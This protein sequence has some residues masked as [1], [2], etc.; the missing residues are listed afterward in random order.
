MEI[1]AVKELLKTSAIAHGKFVRDAEEAERYYRNE[2]DILKRGAVVRKE[3]DDPLRNADNRIPSNFHG[4]LVNQE[5][6]YGFSDPPMFDLGNDAANKRL[7]EILGDRYAKFCKDMCINASNCKVAWAHVWKDDDNHPQYAAIDP[8]QIIPFWTNDLN[9][10]L[11]AVIRSYVELLDDG[12]RYEIIEVWTDTECAVYR[13]L[14]T[15]GTYRTIQPH[16]VFGREEPTNVYRHEFGLVP[17]IPFFNNNVPSNDL[18]NIKSLIDAYDKVYSGFLNDLED[19]QEVIFILSGYS[20]TDLDEFTG[21]LKKYKTVKLDDAG[22]SSGG[23]TTLTIDIP[24]EARE[25]MLN[26]TRKAIFEQGQGI[27]PDPANFGNSSGVALGYLYS[28]LE[29]KMGLKETEFRLGFGELIRVL[30]KF[31]GF[32]VGEIRQTWTRTRVTNDTELADIA[33]KS[34]GIISDKTIIERHPWVEDVEE[35]KKRLE[36]QKAKEDTVYKDAFPPADPIEGD[37]DEE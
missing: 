18:K 31:G 32:E 11:S 20:G 35:E 23:L 16:F 12:K 1:E 13:K 19:I 34:V 6:A 4:L 14:V 26:M 2:T 36:N 27:D 30:G 28:L 37:G 15:A 21:A 9:R 25:K 17:F 33:Q 3:C 7:R 5:A 8:K 22:D 24:V 10:K 29:L